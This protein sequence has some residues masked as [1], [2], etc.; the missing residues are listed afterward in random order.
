ML[1]EIRSQYYKKLENKVLNNAKHFH[2][3]RGMT[4]RKKELLK[5]IKIQKLSD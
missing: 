4:F 1:A 3:V 5:E 2:V